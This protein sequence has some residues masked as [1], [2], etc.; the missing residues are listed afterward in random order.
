MDKIIK[1]KK[2]TGIMQL[3][4]IIIFS[5]VV[6]LITYAKFTLLSSFMSSHWLGQVVSADLFTYYKM[7]FIIICALMAVFLM[8]AKLVKSEIK[9]KL[10]L[11][12]IIALFYGLLVFLSTVLSK[13]PKIA[14]WGAPERQ[15]GAV[16]LVSYMIM[17]IYTISILDNLKSI[18]LVLRC[19]VVSSVIVFSISSLQFLGFD[20]FKIDF[21]RSLFNMTSKGINPYEF[22]INFPDYTTYSTLYNPNNLSVYISLLFPVTVAYFA[23]QKRNINKVFAS[24]LVFLGIFSLIGSSASGGYYAVVA[25]VVILL[26]MTFPY[27]KRNI[28]NVTLLASVVIVLLVM[29]NFINGGRVAQKLN[30]TSPTTEIN[31]FETEGGRIYI[32]NIILGDRE[33]YI[34]T[35]DNDF[36]VLN[37]NNT[38]RVFDN[39]GT[40]M[41][42]AFSRNDKN[43]SLSVNEY[44]INNDEY[45]NYAITTND[46]YSIFTVKA[47]LRTMHFN[48]T[49]KGVM[50]PGMANSLDIIRDVERNEFLYKMPYLFNGRGYIWAGMLPLVEETILIGN[51]PDTTFLTYPQYDYI[52][53]INMLGRFNVVIE[54]PHCYYLQLAHDTGWISLALLLTLF[55]YYIISTFIL[56]LRKK[57]HGLHR[58]YS[59]AI[60]VGIIGYLIASIMYDSSVLTAPVFWTI[61]AVG[62]A[63]NNLIKTGGRQFKKQRNNQITGIK[64]AESL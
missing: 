27:I 17:F 11:P 58:K 29:T 55:G 34:D 25:S 56:L 35:T 6:P 2:N 31:R 30:I 44:T 39:G 51:G 1:P 52:G 8:I 63:L 9:I 26:F 15:E 64:K 19:L 32:N 3:L 43:E 7:V 50:V 14:T 13:Y 54:K 42:T 59:T 36:T 18:K 33:V 61:L 60:M 5:S 4:P 38:I 28:K 37:E 24:L 16:V 53:K 45:E 23:I 21:F 49:D 12:F 20:I 40:E 41:P 47:G 48:V 22:H 46:D 10:S 57:S 62:F